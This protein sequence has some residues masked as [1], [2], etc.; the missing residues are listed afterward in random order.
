[1]AEVMVVKQCALQKYSQIKF[2][3]KHNLF[4][5]TLLHSADALRPRQNSGINSNF[6]HIYVVPLVYTLCYREKAKQK[7]CSEEF[8]IIE[9]SMQPLLYSTREGSTQPI[10]YQLPHIIGDAPLKAL[11]VSPCFIGFFQ[12]DLF[13]SLACVPPQQWER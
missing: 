9:T 3:A 2:C 11:Q 5:S 12:I 7:P 10:S 4:R 8:I 1:M 6:A 13:K